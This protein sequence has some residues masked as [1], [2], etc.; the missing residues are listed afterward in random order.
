MAFATILNNPPILFTFTD[1]VSSLECRLLKN[2]DLLALFTAVIVLW[3]AADAKHHMLLNML[4]PHL[5]NGDHDGDKSTRD[6][7]KLRTTKPPS[8][9]TPTLMHIKQTCGN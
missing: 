6:C 2:R 9:L 3:H 1:Y 7:Q 5:Q 4:F 8:I